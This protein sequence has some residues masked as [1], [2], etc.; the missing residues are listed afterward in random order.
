MPEKLK[1][2]LMI[3]CPFISGVLTVIGIQQLTKNHKNIKDDWKKLFTE[4]K[5]KL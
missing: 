5:I 3:G 1:L 4:K 2:L